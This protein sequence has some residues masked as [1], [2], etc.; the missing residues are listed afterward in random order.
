MAIRN[1]LK[2]FVPMS[3]R[4]LNAR[5]DKMIE[6]ID[7]IEKRLND[8]GSAIRSQSKRLEQIE[9]KVNNIQNQT[10][11][12]QQKT[13]YFKNDLFLETNDKEIDILI[14]MP[15]EKVEKW[16]DW[17]Y[18]EAMKHEFENMGFTANIRTKNRWYDVSTA[19]FVFVL[20][21]RSAY[22][23]LRIPNKKYIMWNISHPDDIPVSEYNLYDLVLFASDRMYQKLRDRILVPS[24]VLLQCAE[25]EFFNTEDHGEY[26]YQL[27][28]IG[29][30][31][32]VYRK[33]LSDLIPTSHQLTVFGSG[34]DQY[35]VNEYVAANF[36][37]RSLVAQ[38]Y[39]DAEI[40]LNDHWDDMRSSGIIS[41]RIFDVFA[42]GGFVISDYMPEIHEIFRD[43][44]V[45]Y[46]TREELAKK[47]DYY[48]AHPAERAK[49]I[50]KGREIVRSNHTFRHRI[51]TIIDLL[52]KL[53]EG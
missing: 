26:K 41:N 18:A 53:D 4:S 29:K 11:D 27:L 52:K 31:R 50:Q 1:W 13:T 49:L 25:N 12:I 24:N 37:D 19:K 51:N 23:P 44:C 38:A 22:I 20:R 10:R 28:F 46:Q 21:G 34:W 7:D 39:H 14:A 35:P 17:F 32:G 48:L 33:I 9:Q 45:T 36:L 16:G 3:S 15:N 47:I 2:Q 30:S 43:A 6:E 40:V 5:L 8:I 42:A